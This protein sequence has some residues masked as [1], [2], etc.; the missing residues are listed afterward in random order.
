M[1]KK[2]K[3]VKVFLEQLN[4]VPNISV[5]CEKVGIARNTIYRWCKEDKEFKESLNIALSCGVDSI[6]DLAESKLVSHINNG[7][8]RAIQYWLD[9]H[10]KEY[11]RPRPKDFWKEPFIP[12]ETI[13]IEAYKDSLDMPLNKIGDIKDS[14]SEDV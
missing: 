4:T 9:N 1:A 8:L 11:M 7:N 13:V 10:K 3:K 5:A 2:D 12:V 6:T 14:E